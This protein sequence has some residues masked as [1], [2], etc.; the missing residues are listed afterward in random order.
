MALLNKEVRFT[1]VPDEVTSRVNIDETTTFYC[2]CDTGWINNKRLIEGLTK[3]QVTITL[4]LH[5]KAVSIG[6]GAH[7]WDEDR[8]VSWYKGRFAASD[9]RWQELALKV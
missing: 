5:G 2:F 3:E 7:D 1:L 6:V 8:Y 9:I 4:D